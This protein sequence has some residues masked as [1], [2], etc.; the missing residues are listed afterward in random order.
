MSGGL[1]GL[2]CTEHMFF[3]VSDKHAGNVSDRLPVMQKLIL[4]SF[5][6]EREAALRGLLPLQR[7]ISKDC[8]KKLVESQ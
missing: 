8:S 5:K 7:L 1:I 4:A 6:G 2:C 3:G